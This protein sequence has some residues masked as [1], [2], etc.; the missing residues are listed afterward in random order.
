M[1]LMSTIVWALRGPNPAWAGGG[2]RQEAFLPL[3]GLFEPSNEEYI[4]INQA[5]KRLQAESAAPVKSLRK[6]TSKQVCR[7]DRREMRGEEARERHRK[8]R[9]SEAGRWQP[10]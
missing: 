1:S 5:V 9:E 2:G 8:R 7:R 6:E 10:G 4:C 3:E